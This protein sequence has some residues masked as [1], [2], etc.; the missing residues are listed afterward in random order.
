MAVEV[1]NLVCSCPEEVEG[2][3]KK[4]K[5]ESGRGHPS[6]PCLIATGPSLCKKQRPSSAVA[7]W[8]QMGESL[9][10]FLSLI[11]IE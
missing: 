2:R 5:F 6:S 8:E 3:Q 7:A 9:V 11:A 10:A 1:S 4:G